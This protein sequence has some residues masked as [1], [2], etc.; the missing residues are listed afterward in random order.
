[1]YDVQRVIDICKDS[2]EVVEVFDMGSYTKIETYYT[3]AC[4]IDE[5]C[6]MECEYVIGVTKSG[7]VVT[8]FK[9]KKSM[10]FKTIEEFSYWVDA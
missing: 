1:M 3:K 7:I 6:V 9:G 8:P 4:F 5:P 2:Y 10:V